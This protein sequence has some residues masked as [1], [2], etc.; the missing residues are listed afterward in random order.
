MFD[1]G[2]LQPR[3]DIERITVLDLPS[4]VCISFH[5]YCV[6]YRLCCDSHQCWTSVFQQALSVSLSL[7]L[8]LHLSRY[9]TST[10]SSHYIDLSICLQHSRTAELIAECLACN[11]SS[12]QCHGGQAPLRLEGRLRMAQEL[13]DQELD[14][15][16]ALRSD[17]S[18]FSDGLLEHILVLHNIRDNF[19]QW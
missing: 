19:L 10:L 7:V 1:A 18:R 5:L 16:A 12:T 4:N 6:T 9:V 8:P 17:I 11:C 15:V 13:L 2:P 14:D 3:H